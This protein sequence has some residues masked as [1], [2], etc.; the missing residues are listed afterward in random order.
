MGNIET[1][2]LFKSKTIWFNILALVVLVA[3]Q[4]GFAEFQPAAWVT[5]I[6]TVIVISINLFLRF[7][8]SQKISLR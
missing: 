4:F 1:K 8:T 7:K 6:G 5:E 2:S 3:A